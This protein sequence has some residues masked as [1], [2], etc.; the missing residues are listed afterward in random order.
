MDYSIRYSVGVDVG[1]GAMNKH[2]AMSKG[3]L[4]YSQEGVL[5]GM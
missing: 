5:F 4:Q 3:R 1:V 2:T